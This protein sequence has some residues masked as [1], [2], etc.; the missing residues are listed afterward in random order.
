MSKNILPSITSVTGSAVQASSS[1]APS[2]NFSQSPAP[3]VGTFPS[4]GSI[5]RGLLSGLS[6]IAAGGLNM[7]G[8]YLAYKRQNK[9]YDK[10]R[11]HALSDY[12]RQRQDYLSD[13]V[14]ERAYNSP[15]AQVARLREAGINPNTVFGSGS[16]SNVSS[17]AR[18]MG[19]PNSSSF[20][21]VS[22]SP[23]G[24]TIVDSIM[25]SMNA[26]LTQ[27]QAKN[28]E[29]DIQEKRANVIRTLNSA[30]LDFSKKRYQDI[31]NRFADSMFQTD[32]S[33]KKQQV[34]S[35]VDSLKTS[36]IE[37]LSLEFDL[38]HLKPS[39]YAKAQ[40]SIA[41][42]QASTDKLFKDI[43]LLTQTYDFTESVKEYRKLEEHMK[44]LLAQYDS[45]V[46]S[47]EVPLELD[48]PRDRLAKNIRQEVR[49]WFEAVTPLKFGK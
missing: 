18:N 11:Q 25:P 44:S 16:V 1:G 9:L 24:S 13:L 10:Q 36:A 34:I 47:Y 32:V 29:M 5:G 28:L 45:Q 46:R 23:I 33:L 38:S 14:S 48:K 21:S 3:A 42:I 15:L 19:M 8:D 17:Q 39:E 12:E 4:L 20:P 49:L 40:A 30:G 37:R 35:L 26:S 27:L 2:T 41:N 7:L 6:G 22:S 43:A 31:A